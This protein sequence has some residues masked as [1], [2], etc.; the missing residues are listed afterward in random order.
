MVSQQPLLSTQTLSS[1]A[2]EHTNL[3]AI[4]VTAIVLLVVRRR[5][6]FSRMHS[7][8]VPIPSGASWIWGHQR[9]VFDGGVGGAY[10]RWAAELSSHVFKIKQAIKGDEIL[11]VLDPTA[12][13]HVFQKHIYEYYQLD[14]PKIARMIGRSIAWVAEEKEHQRMKQLFN[15]ALTAEVVRE[16]AQNVIDAAENFRSYMESY[17]TSQDPANKGI[18]I[19]IPEWTLNATLEVIGRFGFG[20]DFGSGRSPDAKGILSAWRNMTSMITN[21]KNFEVVML[22]RNLP[23]IDSI[24]IKALR[25]YGNVRLSIHE[26]VGTS[27]P[28]LSGLVYDDQLYG[29]DML[30]R[31]LFANRV[32]RLPLVELQDH[33]TTFVMAGSETTSTSISF[34]IWEL[35][36]H[37]EIQEQLRKELHSFPAQPTYDQIMSKMPLLDAVVRE[38]LRMHPAVPYMEREACH[39]DVI[40]LKHSFVDP[41]GVQRSEVVVTAGQKIVVPVLSVNRLD[42]I[43]GDGSVFRPSRW[44]EPLPAKEDLLGGFSHILS[45]S[46]GPRTCVGWRLA[47]FEMKVMVAMLTYNFKFEDTGAE[48]DTKVA[49]SL[50]PIEVGK[51]ELGPRL[52]VKISLA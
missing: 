15:P 44:S 22:F 50:N 28:R 7:P 51:E 2:M 49:S 20:H 17:L 47:L 45:F 6:A 43:W 29:N 40:P 25:S 14:R 41:Q 21:A 32:N 9:L 38:S 12:I 19:S 36:R 37:P 24:P 27:G 42:S 23:F 39:D 4:I 52:P 18:D 26:R 16:G 3:I 10:S 5:L 33:V 13:N 34:A 35:A 31:L 46:D 30:S 48:V 11:I 8:N 1:L